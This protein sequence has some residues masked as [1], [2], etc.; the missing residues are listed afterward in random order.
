MEYDPENGDPASAPA[1]ALNLPDLRGDNV[2][3]GASIER[4]PNGARSPRGYSVPA[5]A[6]VLQTTEGECRFFL[7]RDEASA[8]A[9]GIVECLCDG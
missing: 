5:L 9:A 7:T 6:V 4:L 8:L 2:V 3:L 1:C